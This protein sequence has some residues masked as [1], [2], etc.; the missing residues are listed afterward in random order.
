MHR[1]KSLRLAYL[2]AKSPGLATYWATPWG[3]TNMGQV[4]A[5]QKTDFAAWLVLMG[6]GRGRIS[7][8]AASRVLGLS[9]G[10]V[11]A[12]RE[13]AP[14]PRHIALACAA[15]AFGLPPWRRAA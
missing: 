9:R 10:T 13:G 5:P 12:Y 7:D 14:V 4:E 1:V 3:G 6:R 2:V 15:L 11:K 8:R